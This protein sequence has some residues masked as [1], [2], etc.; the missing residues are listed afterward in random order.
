MQSR[1]SRRPP[2]ISCI[3][4][5]LLCHVGRGSICHFG[6]AEL[7]SV[8]NQHPAQ[9]RLS[10]QPSSS[11]LPSSLPNPIPPLLSPPASA[12]ASSS[13]PACSSLQSQGLP[14]SWASL[15]P[16]YSAPPWMFSIHLWFGAHVSVSVISVSTYL[17]WS[18]IRSN[19]ERGG[20]NNL[21]ITYVCL[22]NFCTH[23]LSLGGV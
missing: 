15:R 3:A 20:M 11:P 1:G 2:N 10:C 16:N 8:R 12:A 4:Y 17:Q 19:G 5:F 18:I 22:W 9:L 23:T 13:L 7:G 14:P 6:L 21:K